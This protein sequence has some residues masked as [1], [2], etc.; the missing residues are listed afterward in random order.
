MSLVS[1]LGGGATCSVYSCDLQPPPGQ[2]GSAKPV[3]VA[4]AAKVPCPPHSTAIELAVLTDLRRNGCPGLP[5]AVY[6]LDNGAGIAMTPIGTPLLLFNATEALW[7]DLHK[8]LPELL[9]ALDMAHRRYLHRDLRPE[10]LLR[11]PPK[12]RGPRLRIID[13]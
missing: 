10:N 9:G 8:G 2:T 11:A 4:V 1:L 5:D 6:E 13:W 3:T 12:R 7:A